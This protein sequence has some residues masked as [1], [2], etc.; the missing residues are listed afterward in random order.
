MEVT[1]L[2]SSSFHPLT[3][4]SRQ[5]ICIELQNYYHH[6]HNYQLLGTN[7]VNSAKCFTGN[8]SNTVVPSTLINMHS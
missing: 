7:Y 8:I 2:S 6:H 5:S 1:T 4:T 3:F